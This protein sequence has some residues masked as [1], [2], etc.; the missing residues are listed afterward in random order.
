MPRLSP[1]KRR[2]GR[3]SCLGCKFCV[4]LENPNRR[5]KLRAG[6]CGLTGKVLNRAT[7]RYG[8]DDRAAGKPGKKQLVSSESRSC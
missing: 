3:K 7:M 8:C 4:R 6:V 2:A 1:S 5:V